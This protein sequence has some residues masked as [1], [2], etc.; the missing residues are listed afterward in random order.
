VQR[1]HDRL[2]IVDDATAFL[3]LE[4][5]DG[6]FQFVCRDPS[7]ADRELMIDGQTTTIDG[8][9]VVDVASAAAVAQERFEGREGSAF[10]RWERR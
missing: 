3:A 7:S 6:L 4:R 2:I 5:T 1:C 10:G 9:H 8:R